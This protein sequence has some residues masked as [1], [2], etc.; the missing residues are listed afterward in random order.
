M[1][2]KRKT[3]YIFLAGLLS[4]NI[5]ACNHAWRFTHFSKVSAQRTKPEDLSLGKKLQTAILGIP[6]PRPHNTIVP[7]QSY[8]TITLQSHETLE[9]WLIEV[10]SSKGVIALFHGYTRCKAHMLSYAREF[11]QLGYSTLLVDFMGSGGSSGNQT[12]IGFK[13]ALDVRVAAD[14][15]QQRFPEKPI[16]LFGESM[17]AVAVM[18]AIDEEPLQVDK[19]ILHCPFGYMKKTTQKRFEAMGIPSFILADILLFYGGLIN[20]FNAFHHNPVEY[21]KSIKLPTLL[22]WGARDAR[23]TRSETDEIFANLQGEKSLGVFTNSGHENY[24]K[25]HQSE[26]R[27]QVKQFLQSDSLQ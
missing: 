12:T 13:E 17:G 16:I 15:L 19:L 9:A 6:N 20:G 27:L 14:Y 1:S 26:W 10:P 8:E 18:K 11:H 4:L 24:L 2:S 22:L 21:A 23:V 5:I 25:Q 3:L 7:S